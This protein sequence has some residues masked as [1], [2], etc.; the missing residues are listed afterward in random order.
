MVLDFQLWHNK[1]QKK[2]LE[3]IPLH[4]GPLDGAA[5][6][7]EVPSHVVHDPGLLIPIIQQ[8]M[9]ESMHTL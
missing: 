2:N 8:T 6:P 4:Y 7:R 5:E 3:V 9:T 1:E